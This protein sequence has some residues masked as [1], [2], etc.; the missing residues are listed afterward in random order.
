MGC[1]PEFTAASVSKQIEITPHFQSHFRYF[2]FLQKVN[3][4]LDN[5]NIPTRANEEKTQKKPK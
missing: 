5:E 3:L 2:P 4:L 1:N